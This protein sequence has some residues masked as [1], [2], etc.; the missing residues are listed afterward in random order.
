MQG[1][2][3]VQDGRPRN[4]GGA[5]PYGYPGSS[6]FAF[7]GMAAFEVERRTIKFIEKPAG[8][9]RYMPTWI[10]FIRRVVQRTHNTVI[11]HAG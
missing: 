1:R 9:F 5:Q 11:E 8:R 4:T 2:L 10:V 3:V 6:E 7:G